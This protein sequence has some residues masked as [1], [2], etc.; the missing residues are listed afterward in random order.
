MVNSVSLNGL[1]ESHPSSLKTATDILF[2]LKP[3]IATSTKIVETSAKPSPLINSALI[4]EP[5]EPLLLEGNFNKWN[6]SLINNFAVNEKLFSPKL[7]CDPKVSLLGDA[8]IYMYIFQDFNEP[9]VSLEGCLQSS[10]R[11][12]KNF[13]RKLN[14]NLEGVFKIKYWYQCKSE[15]DKFIYSDAVERKISVRQRPIPEVMFMD[16][17]TRSVNIFFSSPVKSESISASTFSIGLK[18]NGGRVAKIP[19]VKFIKTE[20]IGDFNGHQNVYKLF[21]NNFI[22]DSTSLVLLMNENLCL[23]ASPPFGNCG[24]FKQTTSFSQISIIQPV[25]W[26]ANLVNSIYNNTVGYEK[27]IISVKY[28]FQEDVGVMINNSII[29]SELKEDNFFI[30]LRKSNLKS[31]N[32]WWSSNNK[33]TATFNILSGNLVRLN[34]EQTY[35]VTAELRDIQ[36]SNEDRIVAFLKANNTKDG[37]AIANVNNLALTEDKTIEFNITSG[38]CCSNNGKCVLVI[39]PSHC[40]TSSNFHNDFSCNCNLPVSMLQATSKKVKDSTISLNGPR[41]ISMYKG[42]TIFDPEIKKLPEGFSFEKSV[43]RNGLA[44]E[45]S[46]LIAHVVGLYK[47]IYNITFLENLVPKSQ[48]LTRF[49]EIRPS[50]PKMILSSFTQGYKSVTVEFSSPPSSINLNTL[51]NVDKIAYP[52][53]LV[54]ESFIVLAT[55]PDGSL[56]KAAPRVVKVEPL[57]PSEFKKTSYFDSIIGST[58]SSLNTFFSATKYTLYLEWSG[59]WVDG[60]EFVIAISD[61]G[62]GSGCY[63]S[64]PPFGKCEMDSIQIPLSIAPKIVYG[65]VEEFYGGRRLGIWEWDS[66][67][68]QLRYL[69]RVV[70][71]K[72][73]LYLLG[74]SKPENEVVIEVSF[75]QNVTS[76]QGENYDLTYES[77]EATLIRADD[78]SLNGLTMTTAFIDDPWYWLPLYLPLWILHQIIPN[79]VRNP[80]VKYREG[81]AVVGSGSM[82]VVNM[83]DLECGIP[84]GGVPISIV[85]VERMGDEPEPDVE[86]AKYLQ[87]WRINNYVDSMD[88]WTIFKILSKGSM[89][90]LWIGMLEWFIGETKIQP[91]SIP[92]IPAMPERNSSYRVH[93]TLPV[94]E[95]TFQKGDMLVI[96]IVDGQVFGRDGG[97]LKASCKPMFFDVYDYLKNPNSTAKLLQDQKKF[98]YWE[99]LSKATNI[100]EVDLDNEKKLIAAETMYK[101]LKE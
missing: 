84:V 36:L 80:Y 44:L 34:G 88:L 26:T 64:K 79:F 73:I 8:Q 74:F 53:P 27:L 59:E 77:F 24:S 17:S 7:K 14:V 40:S 10:C 37:S 81:S 98:S 11:L 20:I 57:K 65:G 9:G 32:S 35:M 4:D 82:R 54:I 15:T 71:R 45:S 3:I 93:L 46:S 90:K 41:Y 25:S 18:A 76:V 56:S 97:M 69:F 23:D 6:L 87:N 19:K 89:R 72:S 70:W 95:E 91:K 50:P 86:Y 51:H 38:S 52:K 47:I 75:S 43:D 42:E 94:D 22:S 78:D 29:L 85:D 96:N 83:G 31:V 28:V 13:N 62:K 63:D 68:S 55:R 49:V 100:L 67:Y 39:N 5:N 33:N 48:C 58:W 2:F 1:S 92:V 30:T 16:P 21:Y 61:S 60:D 12:I 99:A 101:K 66:Y